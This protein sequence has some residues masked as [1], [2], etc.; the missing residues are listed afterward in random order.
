MS[1]KKILNWLL[2]LQIPTEEELK[3]FTNPKTAKE[4][5]DLATTSQDPE[6]RATYIQY[7]IDK[8]DH[9]IDE[10]DIATPYKLSYNSFEKICELFELLSQDKELYFYNLAKRKFEHDAT[11]AAETNY[12]KKE[13]T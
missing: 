3:I 7:C 5:L 2:T 11:T 1:D 12:G 10:N 8:F 6:F 13:N 9:T 4:F